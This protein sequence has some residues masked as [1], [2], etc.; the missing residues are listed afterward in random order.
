MKTSQQGRNV[1]ARREGVQA[2]AYLDSV[3]VW[4]IGVGHT[5]AAGPPH[6]V[7][8]LVMTLQ[9]VMDLF[10]TDLVK[11]ENAVTG[12]VKVP[13]TQNQ[14]DAM[15]SLCYNIGPGAFAAS[16]LVRDLNAGNSAGA[17]DDFMHFVKPPELRGRREQEQAQFLSASPII[18]MKKPVH[19]AVVAGGAVVIAIG[20]GASHVA[21][22]APSLPHWLLPAVGIVAAGAAGWFLVKHFCKGA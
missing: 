5:S 18:P 3:G 21:N 7:E 17:A 16:E 9:E 4:T 1:L 20:A 2:R 8:G 19:P 10:A 12:A 22:A 14:F 6:V 13:V 11:Y 15:V